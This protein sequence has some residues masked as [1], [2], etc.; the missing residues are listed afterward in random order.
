MIY[1]SREL[2]KDDQMKANDPHKYSN[3]I[4]FDPLVMNYQLNNISK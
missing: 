4:E 2:K 1:Y 3:L